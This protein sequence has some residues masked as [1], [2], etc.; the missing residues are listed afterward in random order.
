MS[1]SDLYSGYIYGQDSNNGLYYRAEDTDN[2]GRVELYGAGDNGDTYAYVLVNNGSYIY[3]GLYETSPNL[4]WI[5]K[6][7]R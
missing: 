3:N 5:S 1:H 7:R 6:L 4:R 2:D